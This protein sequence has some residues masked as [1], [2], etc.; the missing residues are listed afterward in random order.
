MTVEP[1]LA[2]RIRL[3]PEVLL[4]RRMLRGAAEIHLVKDLR[5]GRAFEVTAR[6]HF[7]MTRLDG[8]LSLAEIGDEYARAFRRR[9]AAPHWQQLLGLLGRR[10]LLDVGPADGT[11]DTG[12][13]A[14]AEGGTGT[15]ARAG[16]E[17]VADVGGGPGVPPPSRVSPTVVEWSH[18]RVRWLLSRPAVLALLG[19]ALA[20]QVV[21]AVRLDEALA[22]LRWLGEHPL[23]L[24]PVAVLAW[25]S[26]ALHELAH[27]VAARH[28]GCA[29][30][31]IS[32]VTLRCRV[33][34]YLYLPS[35]RAQIVIAA[36]GGLANGVLML[37]FGVV[38]LVLPPTAPARPALA[39]ILLIGSVQALVNFVPLPPLDG[40]K[41]V[42]HAFGVT[43]LYTGTR[44]FLW[45]AARAG[46]G[47][48]PGIA[49]YPLRA[50]VYYLGYGLILLVLALAAGT[51]IVLL[52]RQLGAGRLGSAAVVV[53]IAAVA[54]TV[55]GWLA[56]PRR[57]PAVPDTTDVPDP[58]KE[59]NV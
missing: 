44:Q 32:V 31:G 56:R 5:S 25:G 51:A 12:T 28:F 3:H 46:A 4:S 50:R 18:R 20:L 48:G 40:Y 26:A 59:G 27:G 42:S 24:L 29:V 7:I 30:T 55:A 38:W 58:Q 36:A 13:G 35:A 57:R 53:T 10:G 39:G 6:E 47:R 1:L 45:Q 15:P 49:A 33:D 9:L 21:V 8:R 41:V 2:K 34:S 37:P 16:Q 19:L 52:G 43:H 17:A 23:W 54:M 14:S 22:G 11:P